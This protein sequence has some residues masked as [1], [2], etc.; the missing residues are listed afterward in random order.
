MPNMPL[1]LS[2]PHNTFCLNPSA[3]NNVRNKHASYMNAC[4][5]MTTCKECKIL[6]TYLLLHSTTLVSH[7]VNPRDPTGAAAASG[8]TNDGT[9]PPAI[10]DRTAAGPAA[11]TELGD[12][13]LDR[14]E[15]WRQAKLHTSKKLLRARTALTPVRAK[16][17]CLIC[18]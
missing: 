7:H 12:A 6:I 1:V 18:L 8:I 13:V 16:L 11:G 2:M 15:K 3:E 9:R 5:D 4:M 10:A 14:P 17:I